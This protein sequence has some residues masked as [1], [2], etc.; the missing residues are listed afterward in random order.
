MQ[1]QPVVWESLCHTGGQRGCDLPL[2]LLLH[3][4][5]WHI[6]RP[7]PNTHTHMRWDLPASTS[8]APCRHPAFTQLC[9]KLPLPW[10]LLFQAR[11]LSQFL[12]LTPVLS[13]AWVTRIVS[14]L[15]GFSK[16]TESFHGTINRRSFP[17]TCA[18]SG[19]LDEQGPLSSLVLSNP[20]HII[21]NEAP[22]YNCNTQIHLFSP[23][24]SCSLGLPEIM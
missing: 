19:Q 11:F 14:S 2:H 4:P 18:S 23:P 10:E 20:T 3:I 8:R 24:V 7:F 21:L 22:Q 17:V 12:C 5:T 16:E 13:E 9:S 15:R 1:L 6:Q